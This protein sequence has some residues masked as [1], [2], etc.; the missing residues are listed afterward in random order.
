VE[1]LTEQAGG[2]IVL[3]IQELKEEEEKGRSCF[4][5]ADPLEKNGDEAAKQ[6][7]GKDCMS[8]KFFPKIFNM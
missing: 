1:S 2:K 3:S 5:F 6:E 8:K 4:L 7:I